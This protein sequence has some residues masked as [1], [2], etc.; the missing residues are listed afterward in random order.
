ML[1]LSDKLNRFYS[2]FKKSERDVLKVN[3]LILYA[4][5][6]TEDSPLRMGRS[7]RC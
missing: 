2:D 1:I 7:V 5:W 3:P 6:L 4:S